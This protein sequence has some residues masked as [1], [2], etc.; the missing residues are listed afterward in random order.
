MK[1]AQ[2]ESNAM[3]HRSRSPLFGTLACGHRSRRPPR[4]WESLASSSRR[5][6]AKGDVPELAQARVTR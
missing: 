6:E 5:C 3:G 4:A 1:G 2:G